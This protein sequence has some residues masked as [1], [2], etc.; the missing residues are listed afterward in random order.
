MSQTSNESGSSGTPG[1]PASTTADGSS[2]S[3][4]TPP[5]LPTETPTGASTPS[6]VA[7]PAS[8]LDPPSPE[9]GISEA[10]ISEAGTSDDEAT[11]LQPSVEDETVTA[12]EP[13]ASEDPEI[14]PES[15]GE[16]TMVM[17]ADTGRVSREE[18]YARQD[19]QGER[20]RLA[21]VRAEHEATVNPP[22]PAEPAAAAPLTRK[23]RRRLTPVTDRFFGS[24]GLF[25]LRLTLAVPFGV[26]G[27]QKLLGMDEAAA[28]FESLSFFGYQLPV[29]GPLAI[30]TG[31]GEV[32]IA[33]SLLVGFLTRFAGIGMM[34]ISIGALIMVQWT[35]MPDLLGPEAVGVAGELELVL[36]GAGLLV[37]CIGAGGWSLDRL[38][39]RER[40]S[41]LEDDA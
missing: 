11:V 19:R 26:H 21:A 15:G 32:L 8:P 20:E 18:L 22:P 16:K 40:P 14:D 39:R 3:G 4:S 36:A 6:G 41:G 33:V 24:L 29:P 5:P 27:V 23:Q 7:P 17:P 13:V 2:S 25:V 1:T 12:G 28:F 31:V 35:S 30:A 10:G 9:A 34:I 38:F 37:L